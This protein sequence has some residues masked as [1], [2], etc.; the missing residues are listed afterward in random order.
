MRCTY[1]ISRRDS[2]D[3]D[4]SGNWMQA[5]VI[6][7]IR[8]IEP[9]QVHLTITVVDIYCLAELQ[10][11]WRL[12]ISAVIAVAVDTDM[13][14]CIWTCGWNNTSMHGQLCWLKPNRFTP[15]ITMLLEPQACVAFQLNVKQYYYYSKHT[16]V[17]EMYRIVRHFITSN[18]ILTSYFL[19][20]NCG[21]LYWF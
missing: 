10:I 21:M 13:W 17:S 8:H 6:S 15:I 11:L 2:F 9:N 20:L 7:R 5:S 16:I 1:A 3:L 19:F 12:I 14:R 4:F 18:C